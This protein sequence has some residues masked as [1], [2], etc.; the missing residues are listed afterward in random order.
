ME[1]RSNRKPYIDYIIIIIG[2][3][4]LATALNMFFIPL[5]LVTGGVTGL[6]IVVKKITESIVPGGIPPWIT[7]IVINIP[8]FLTAIIIKGKNFGGRS[9]FST[10]YLSFALIYTSYLPQ[11]T[12]D[13][14]L[15]SVFGGALAG[16]GLGLVFSAYSTT[17]GTD[18]AGSIIQH[19]IGH[20]SVAQI[21][22]MLDAIIILSGYFIFGA[23]KAMYAL[24]AVF[25]TAKIVD[26]ILEGIHFSKAA[27]IISDNNEQISKEIMSQLDRGVT[28]L[29]GTG[30]FSKQRKEVLLCV[31]SKKEIVKLKEIVREIDKN[32]FV[33]VADVK[34]VVGEGFIEYR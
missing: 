25:I 3:T 13:I 1:L 29:Q 22:L 21:M 31:V 33:I 12:S 6:A 8:L 9:L 7:N 27:F 23:E 10:F 18:L 32:S 19:Y 16:I 2:T 34:E 14:L 30:K 24:V 28:G 26:A 20:Y 5:D 17:G 4:L 11:P 15:G